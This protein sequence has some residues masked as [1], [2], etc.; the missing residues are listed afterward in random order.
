MVSLVAK[1]S[2]ESWRWCGAFCEW[3]GST[4]S[5]WE[6]NVETMR[7]SGDGDLPSVL[8]AGG[9]RKGMCLGGM[10]RC[11]KGVEV[12]RYEAGSRLVISDDMGSRGIRRAV[13][14]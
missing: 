11:S 8:C 3:N 14:L 13:D 1:G 12:G 10:T 7:A 6:L 9:R 2:D 5:V 4:R